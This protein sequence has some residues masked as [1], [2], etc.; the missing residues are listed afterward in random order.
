M[1]Y[2]RGPSR[3]CEKCE[4]QYYRHKLRQPT[5]E[6][7]HFQF[8]GLP[9]A[10][11]PEE[12]L[13]QTVR[14]FFLLPKSSALRRV[15]ANCQAKSLGE[16]RSR[17]RQRCEAFLRKAVEDSTAT[18]L[19]SP[20][21]LSDYVLS[22][23]DCGSDHPV[24]DAIQA[25]AAFVA[26]EVLVRGTNFFTESFSIHCYGGTLNHFLKFPPNQSQGQHYRD[27]FPM[28]RLRNDRRR[29]R[30]RER[31]RRRTRRPLLA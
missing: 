14:C 3:S 15:I 21:P 2:R 10:E 18:E 24:R 9:P 5:K 20:A 4:L 23:F 29:R 25:T 11:T 13:I 30:Q 8:F 28:R 12:D 6:I 17:L 31:G 7:D 26:P 27:P 19:S 22:C 1:L 16:Q